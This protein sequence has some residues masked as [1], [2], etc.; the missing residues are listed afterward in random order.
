[1][2]NEFPIPD[3][4]AAL[5]QELQSELLP[6]YNNFIRVKTQALNAQEPELK[7]LL[8]LRASRLLDVMRDKLIEAMLRLLEA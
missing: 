1:M 3:C 4:I 5:P 2:E 6:H 7:V 8:L